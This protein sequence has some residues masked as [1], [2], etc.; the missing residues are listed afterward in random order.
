MEKDFSEW[1]RVKQNI[2]NFKKHLFAAEREVRWCFVGLNVG[3]EMDGSGA[4]YARP[5]L[6]IKKMSKN[7]CLCVPITTKNKYWPDYFNIDLRDGVFRMVI[8]SQIK[9]I[10]TKRLRE[11]I[12]ILD[13][14]QFQKIKTAIIDL[15]K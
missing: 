13:Q 10:D 5:V 7:T 1:H 9:L 11:V 2:Q 3:S 4:Y 15:I 14:D 12:T 8:L 6:V